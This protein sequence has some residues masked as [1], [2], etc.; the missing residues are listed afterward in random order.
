MVPR[1]SRARRRRQEEED[2]DDPPRSTRPSKPSRTGWW[3]GLACAGVAVLAG[4]VAVFFWLHIGGDVIAR[5]TY[6]NFQNLKFGVPFTDVESLLGPGDPVTMDEVR[7]TFGGGGIAKGYLVNIGFNE[8][9]K[10]A[11]GSARY[12]W[13]N[14]NDAILMEVWEATGKKT[15]LCA[16]W[17]SSEGTTYAAEFHTLT[18]IMHI[19]NDDYF[20][21]KLYP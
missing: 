15:V 13:R 21:G 11:N 20:N 19:K 12:R 18:G 16:V 1:N 5:V 10:F 7:R 6:K 17:V 4:G 2:F 3:I 14:G 9:E 8:Y